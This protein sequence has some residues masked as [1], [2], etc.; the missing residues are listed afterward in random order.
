MLVIPCDPNVGPDSLSRPSVEPHAVDAVGQVG[1]IEVASEMNIGEQNVQTG[2]EDRRMDVV[3]LRFMHQFVRQLQLSQ[4][5]LAVILK[6][7][8]AAEFLAVGQTCLAKIFVELLDRLR[9]LL[10]KL[11]SEIGER[12][13][14]FLKSI[15]RRVDAARRVLLPR[16]LSGCVGRPTAEAVVPFARDDLQPHLQR[17]PAVVRKDQRRIEMQFL[18]EK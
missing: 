1:A 11:L 10:S 2:I 4:P 17:M 16:R 5:F 3:P 12:D 6:L 7:L 9:L 8:N 13:G 18:Q 15:L 14:R